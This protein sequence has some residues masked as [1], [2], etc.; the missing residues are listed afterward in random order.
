LIEWERDELRSALEALV[1]PEERAISVITVS[2]L[3]HRVHRASGARRNRRQAFVEHVLAGLEPVP[4]TE[5]VARVHAELWA[6][7]DRRG[8]VP[9]AHDLWIAATALAHGYAVATRNKRDFDRVPGLRVLA[10][11][12]MS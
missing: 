3:L 1:G 8:D 10:P 5:Q 11:N 7:L 4:I 12:S 6:D 2:E 9:G